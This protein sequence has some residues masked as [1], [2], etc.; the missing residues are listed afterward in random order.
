VKSR[1][2]TIANAETAHRSITPGH[3]AYVSHALSTP[4]KWD[5]KAEK[6]VGNDE[7]QKKLI[8]LPYRGDWELGGA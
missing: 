7:A 5:P 2:D 3:I 8:A 6:V 4:I 1:E